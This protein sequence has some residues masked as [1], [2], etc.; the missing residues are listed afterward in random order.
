VDMPGLRRAIDQA[1]MLAEQAV[2]RQIRSGA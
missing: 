1:L 2:E